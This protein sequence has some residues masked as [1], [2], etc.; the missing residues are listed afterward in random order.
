[1][2]MKGKQGFTLVELLVV[3]TIIIVLAGLSFTIASKMMAKG[4]AT[5]VMENLRQMGPLIT[6]YAADHNM[7]LPPSRIQTELADGTATNQYWHQALLALVFP[8]TDP[9]DFKREAWWKSNDTFMR[10]PLFKET[11]K[12]RGWSPSNPG[13]GLNEMIAENLAKA[14][15]E[16]PSREELETIRT[17]LAAI[18]EPSRT[19]LVAPCDNYYYRYDEAEMV[20]FKFGT[21]KDFLSDGKVPVLF[22]DGHVEAIIPTEYLTRKLDE[23]PKVPT[24]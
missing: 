7:A 18:S 23:M 8:N 10:N 17:P 6:I 22:V 5:K 9:D 11:A 13:Y 1:M 3:I 16:T 19:P 15:G 2:K 24:Q 20:S 12:P 4:K 14:K 21:L